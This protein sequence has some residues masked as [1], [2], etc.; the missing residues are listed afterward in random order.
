MKNS[1]AI[2]FSEMTKGWK[3]K[4]PKL[5]WTPY[6]IDQHRT[7]FEEY[8]RHVHLAWDPS[9][10]NW[11]QLHQRELFPGSHSTSRSH[12]RGDE[13]ESIGLVISS[14]NAGQPH[15]GQGCS[16]KGWLIQEP[17]GK[18]RQRREN[19]QTWRIPGWRST[20]LHGVWRS[21]RLEW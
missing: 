8:E 10:L 5:C 21:W 7:D 15:L 4:L 9:L 14:N 6:S 13:D 2:T 20:K 18:R 1:V 12:E 3:M 16:N 11:R 17:K 19:P